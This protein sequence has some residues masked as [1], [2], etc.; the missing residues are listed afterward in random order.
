MLFVFDTNSLISAILKPQGLP[1]LALDVAQQ[2]GKLVFSEET[3]NELLQVVARE[4]FEKYIAFD[5]RL[6]TAL[7]IVEKSELGLISSSP[8][9]ECRDQN[10]LIFLKLAF[11]VNADCIVSGDIH[12][13]ELNPFHNIPIL[14]PSKFLEWINKN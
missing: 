11:S 12:L 13:K 14:A 10:D 8:K 1:K 7:S 4:K 2:K 9:I 6:G 5:T 3:K